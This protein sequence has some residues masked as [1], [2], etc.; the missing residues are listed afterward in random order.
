[1]PSSEVKI[2]PHLLPGTLAEPAGAQTLVIFAHGSGS[3][4]HSPRNIEVALRLQQMGV[5]TVL[6]DLL[7]EEE[8][9]DRRNVFDIPLLA[10]RV[11]EA[12]EWV[13]SVPRTAKLSIG[14]FGASTGAAA[15]L[16]AA[17]MAPERFQPSFHAAAARYGASSPRAS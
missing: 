8:S 15:A 2:G 7:S 6:F 13:R 16:V 11:V 14:L 5:A 9:A 10:E 3:G 4:R 1:M 12:L 17:A